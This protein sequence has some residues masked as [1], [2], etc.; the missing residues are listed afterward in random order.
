MKHDTEEQ[1]RG[2][3][4][5]T[6]QKPL[7]SDAMFFKILDHVGFRASPHDSHNVL[8]QLMPTV[9]HIMHDVVETHR[10]EVCEKVKNLKAV[11]YML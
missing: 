1:M 9:Y 6:K 7:V 2:S 3:L 11:V 5:E 8:E 4:S 10:P